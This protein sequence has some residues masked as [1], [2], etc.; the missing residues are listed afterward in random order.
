MF[1]AEISEK[2]IMHETTLRMDRMRAA[3][4]P[5]NRRFVISDK[6][7]FHNSLVIGTKLLEQFTNDT[8][9]ADQWR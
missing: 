7:I 2:K 9:M 1:Y 5:V 3:H 6:K 4:L 8:I